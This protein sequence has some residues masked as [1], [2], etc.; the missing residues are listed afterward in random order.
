P[1]DTS[2]THCDTSATPC[3]TRTTLCDGCIPSGHENVQQLEDCAQLTSSSGVS[4]QFDAVEN[5]N[6]VNDLT[7]WNNGKPGGDKFELHSADN[8]LRDGTNTGP[9]ETVSTKSDEGLESTHDNSEQ[10][11]QH[12]QNFSSDSSHNQLR[13]SWYPKEVMDGHE[14]DL[15]SNQTGVREE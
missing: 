7:H 2:A 10:S 12:N 15:D 6:S 5:V 3:D 11:A 13:L 9:G 1:C 8:N 14:K 4:I